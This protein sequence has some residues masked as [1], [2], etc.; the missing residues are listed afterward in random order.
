[1]S[2]MPNPLSSSSFLSDPTFFLR[3]LEARKG[4]PLGISGGSSRKPLTAAT[5]PMSGTTP[6]QD[7]RSRM[8]D[9][10]TVAASKPAKPATPNPVAG[11][12]KDR[13]MY[14]Q[15]RNAAE[16]QYRNEMDM[17][18]LGMMSGASV[19]PS[20]T[21]RIQ[22]RY[23][24][25]IRGIAAQERMAGRQELYQSRTR[26]R[27]A[28]KKA[29]KA[30][31]NAI[32]GE[33]LRR[34]ADRFNYSNLTGGVDAAE[35]KNREYL[36][37]LVSAYTPTPTAPVAPA[38]PAPSPRSYDLN[39]AIVDQYNL[40]QQMLGQTTTG[41]VSQLAAPAPA[42]APAPVARRAPGVSAE[43]RQTYGLDQNLQQ[44]LATL[45]PDQR[46]AVEA[47]IAQRKLVA[48]AGALG[49]DTT[50]YAE[51]ANRGFWENVARSADDVVRSLESIGDIPYLGAGLRALFGPG[52]VAG[53][54]LQQDLA[55]RAIERAQTPEERAAAQ[56]LAAQAAMQGGLQDLLGG[57]AA[58]AR[59]PQP[60]SP[61]ANPRPIVDNPQVV[62]QT[63]PTTSRVNPPQVAPGWQKGQKFPSRQ[64]VPGMG[65]F[66]RPESA[67]V[68]MEPGQAGQV[69]D[70]PQVQG[71]PPYQGGLPEAT[72]P[73]SG[74]MG[75]KVADAQPT[76]QPGQAP[77]GSAR[78]PF[79]ATEPPAN[80]QGFLPGLQPPDAPLSNTPEQALARFARSP[81][82][83]NI[84]HF[85]EPP[86]LP[87]IPDPVRT[88]AVPAA[89]QQAQF[90]ARQLRQGRLAKEQIA[91]QVAAAQAAE[92]LKNLPKTTVTD[93]INEALLDLISKTG[94]TV[95]NVPKAVKRGAKG[96]VEGFKSGRA[97]RLKRESEG[98]ANPR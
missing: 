27:V 98:T 1:M 97:D 26:E 31:T 86:L 73:T 79:P 64:Q 24:N 93:T 28:S 35:Q 87:G 66:Y 84:S 9:A 62:G 4:Q 3:E 41:A 65:D 2:A 37:K 70:M 74:P 67:T 56:A 12:P 95:S 8:F 32:A 81:A 77:I 15:L 75:M 54:P 42:P 80:M 90:E 21:Q 89:V 20:M 19:D 55:Q 40:M 7:P 78:S 92:A 68:Q 61:M 25:A 39:Q 29:A 91:R 57:V 45:T 30:E 52:G 76:I 53:A 51:I 71:R 14:D 38:A 88:P 63:A 48:E 11:L 17:V 49:F 46:A 72:V 13:A 22:Q 59:A 36:D 94:Q 60:A 50:G 6:E 16:A 23:T 44:F 96:A 5:Q 10:S 43:D 34:D 82:P 83:S 58:G 33:F 47:Q 18:K 69:V 85:A